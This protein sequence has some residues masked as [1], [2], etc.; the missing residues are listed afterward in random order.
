MRHPGRT[1]TEDVD[2]VNENYLVNEATG[3]LFVAL[4]AALEKRL[5]QEPRDPGLLEL[6][7]E[8]AGQETDFA[9]QVADYTAAIKIL[10]EQPTRHA[11]RPARGGVRAP[12]ATLSPPRG[13]VRQLAKMARSR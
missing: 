12:A 5:G 6:R 3:E 9:R 11:G 2:L 1:Q 4:L 7:A 8:L 10:A 13:R